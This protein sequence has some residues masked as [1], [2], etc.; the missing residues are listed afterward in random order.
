MELVDDDDVEGVGVQISGLQLCQRLN[1]RK[2]VPPLVGP[3]PIHVELA[4]VPVIQHLAEGM[5]TLLQDL[6]GVSDKQQARVAHLR[7]QALEVEGGDDGLAGTRGGDHQ[8]LEAVVAFAF[9][10][11]L[12]ENLGLMRPG[13]DVQ[14]T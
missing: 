8:V 1:G 3:V 11:E 10:G 4:E 13:R 2:H 5:A 12:F 9:G 6:P 7:A 14:K